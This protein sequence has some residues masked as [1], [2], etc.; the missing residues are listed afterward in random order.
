MPLEH[1]VQ[2]THAVRLNIISAL[3][4]II[5]LVRSLRASFFVAHIDSSVFQSTVRKLWCQLMDLLSLT[6]SIIAIVGLSGYATRAIRRLAAIRGAP[7]IVLALSNEITDLHLVVTAI[8]DAFK[9]QQAVMLAPASRSSS[10]TSIM[11]S[12]R[13]ALDKVQELEAMYNRIMPTARSASRS[14]KFSKLTW[15]RLLREQ[16]KLRQMLDDLKTTRLKL[17]LALGTLTLYA[18]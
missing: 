15:L 11:S 14:I 8:Q 13:Q 18:E 6:A 7:D 2:M 1:V 12:L 9:K 3:Q 10:D 4:R 16:S 5:R 17:G